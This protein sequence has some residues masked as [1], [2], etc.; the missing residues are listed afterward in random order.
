MPL[1]GETGLQSGDALLTH[2]PSWKGRLVQLLAW[3]R[4]DH[5]AVLAPHPESGLPC[6]Y[7]A[8]HAA[9]NCLVTHTKRAGFR[10]R[11]L[12]E[13]LEDTRAGGCEVWHVP[14][15]KSDSILEKH[16]GLTTGERLTNLLE[17]WC[18]C[19]IPY[20]LEGAF[21]ARTLGGRWATRWLVPC[22]EDQSAL[23]CSEAV[24]QAWRALGLIQVKNTA[25]YSPGGLVRLAKSQGVCLKPRRV[26]N[27]V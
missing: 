10:C 22:K 3:D 21:R 8:D 15:V 26:E 11:P 12:K 25:A 4:F 6:V 18:H 27:P 24:A 2:C 20:D 19:R 9:A 1:L 5:I 23:F 13:W 14:L 17:R 16:L 7:E